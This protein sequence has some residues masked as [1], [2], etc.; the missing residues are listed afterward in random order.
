MLLDVAATDPAR[1]VPIKTETREFYMVGYAGPN[2][3][4]DVVYD[5][6]LVRSWDDF[7]LP[8]GQSVYTFTVPIP[9]G[10]SMIS[11]KATLTYKLG[12]D[13]RV[14]QETNASFPTK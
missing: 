11:V 1:N 10:V 5:N 4:G 13:V 7:S 2:K 8:P 3:T 14:I 6:W 9:P 12:D